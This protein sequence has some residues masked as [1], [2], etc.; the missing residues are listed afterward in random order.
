[1]FVR[2][3]VLDL[4]LP[5]RLHHRTSDGDIKLVTE[6]LFTQI[7]RLFATNRHCGYLHYVLLVM[8]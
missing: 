2:K 1:M 8:L 5:L 3:A 4:V 6:Q 7:F